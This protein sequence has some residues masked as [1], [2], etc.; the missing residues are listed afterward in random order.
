V[1][2]HPFRV[3]MTDG[4]VYDVRHPEVVT[5]GLTAWRYYH[6]PTPDQFIERYDVLSYLSIARIERAIS[7]PAANNGG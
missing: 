3:V 6:L 2:F 7:K 5:P 4:T 1:P